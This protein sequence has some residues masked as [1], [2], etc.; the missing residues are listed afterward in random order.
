MAITPSYKPEETE[1]YYVDK[2]AV[3]TPQVNPMV[4]NKY[5][6]G[7]AEASAKDFIEWPTKIAGQTE[8]GM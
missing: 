4:A 3:M 5:A 1:D 8:Q 6:A 7:K 2:G